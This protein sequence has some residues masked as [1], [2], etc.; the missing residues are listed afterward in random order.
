MFIPREVALYVD[1]N[2]P[3][4]PSSP[5]T[6]TARVPPIGMLL[7]RHAAQASVAGSFRKVALV[8]R[9]ILRDAV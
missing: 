3:T 4:L 8:P 9:M 1:Y 2:C 6:V 7:V 5:S